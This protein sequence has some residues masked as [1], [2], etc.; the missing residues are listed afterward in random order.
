MVSRV[1]FALVSFVAL[2]SSGFGQDR[3]HLDGAPQNQASTDLELR[4]ALAA[5]ANEIGGLRHAL[6]K[7]RDVLAAQ[8]AA[9]AC[10]CKVEPKTREKLNNSWLQ[11]VAHGFDASK[12]ASRIQTAM[13]DELTAA[14]LKAVVGFDKTNLGQ[15]IIAATLGTKPGKAEAP[16]QDRLAAE[17]AKLADAGKVLAADP[18]RAAVIAELVE[19]T[20]AVKGQIDALMGVALG[21]L[22]GS[23]AAMP[24]NR[25]QPAEDEISELIA[26]QRVM[27]QA[28]FSSMMPQAFQAMYAD[29]AT[30]DLQT[31][32][33]WRKS[34]PA[35]NFQRVQDA[36]FVAA[37][38]ATSE[39][40]G[41]H[42]ARNMEGEEL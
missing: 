1:A 2:T 24:S 29:I 33:T 9:A 30:D 6:D 21:S 40:I 4:R 22:K 3:T 38:Q 5:Q 28:A 19:V 36:S 26:S 18:R 17:M 39:T 27:M 20:D 11:A 16:S 31:Y 23:A 41:R 25:P 15:R 35:R 42:F 10:G 14:D 32:V 13:T 12:M 8:D 7:W 34:P 37:L